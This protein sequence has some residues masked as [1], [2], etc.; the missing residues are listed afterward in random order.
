[1]MVMSLRRMVVVVKMRIRDDGF[2]ALALMEM[3]VISHSDDKNIFNI[4]ICSFH[5]LS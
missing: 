2:L 3:M 5:F 4:N 1:M